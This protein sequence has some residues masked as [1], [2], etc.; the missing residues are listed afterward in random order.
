VT[1]VV[2]LLGTA[3][4]PRL[5]GISEVHGGSFRIPDTD[6]VVSGLTGTVLLSTD[7]VVVEGMAFRFMHGQGRS[8]GRIGFAD[9][10][11][12][13]SLRGSVADLEYPLFSG[14]VPR[15]RGTWHLEGP[16]DALELSGDLEV[17]RA[18]LRRRDDLATILMDGPE[19]AAGA[20]GPVLESG[21]T[22]G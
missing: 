6:S 17:D 2:E 14:L 13:L 18:V 9:G 7:T 8:S 3:A 1:G 5:E 11:V 15:L 4:E 22:C 21:S 12:E 19:E 20:R 16:V 10:T